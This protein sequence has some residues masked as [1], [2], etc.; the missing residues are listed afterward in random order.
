MPRHRGRRVHRGRSRDEGVQGASS[1]AVRIGNPSR[2]IGQAPSRYQNYPREQVT[3]RDFRDP[4][5]GEKHNRNGGKRNRVYLSATSGRL[6]IGCFRLAV[7]CPEL[8]AQ[9]ASTR[10]SVAE[11]KVKDRQK[12]THSAVT[13]ASNSDSGSL[14]SPEPRLALCL[15]PCLPPAPPFAAALAVDEAEAVESRA[16][17]R[18]RPRVIT[19]VLLAAE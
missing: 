19:L 18:T 4:P 14:S 8:R 7:G 3:V 9:Q 2:Q 15:P 11:E 6:R 1:H 16:A 10:T 5:L 17:R 13:A 12:G